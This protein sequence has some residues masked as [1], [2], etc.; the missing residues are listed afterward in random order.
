M[1]TIY[2]HQFT[3]FQRKIFLHVEF[4][5]NTVNCFI[6]WKKNTIEIK[7]ALNDNLLELKI[8]LKF[9]YKYYRKECWPLIRF[10]QYDEI[11]YRISS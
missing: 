11:A 10:N 2:A 4:R 5:A 6:F 9:D 7:I 8:L 3:C 1:F